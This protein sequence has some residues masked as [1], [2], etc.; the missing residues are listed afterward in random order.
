[1]GR[2][3]K[4]DF[5]N[6]G[7]YI[8]ADE[9]A[10]ELGGGIGILEHSPVGPQAR[11]IP[12]CVITRMQ[13]GLRFRGHLPKTQTEAQNPKKRASPPLAK[14]SANTPLVLER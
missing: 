4:S 2:G 13:A 9:S 14:L 1:M 3:G 6:V 5:R 10:P 11:G 12:E 8:S 7:I